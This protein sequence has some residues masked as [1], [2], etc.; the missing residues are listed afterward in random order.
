MVL[1]VSAIHFMKG[2]LVSEWIPFVLCG[3]KPMEVV[4]VRHVVEGVD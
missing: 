3:Y 4:G 2:G 1:F